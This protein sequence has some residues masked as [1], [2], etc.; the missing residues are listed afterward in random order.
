MTRSAV[1]SLSYVPFPRSLNPNGYSDA[2]AGNDLE[3]GAYT[4]LE[5]SSAESITQ[6]SAAFRHEGLELALERLGHA[7]AP[8][9]GDGQGRGIGEDVLVAFLQ[10]IEDALRRRL[11]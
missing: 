9:L 1:I 7:H 8:A 6:H 2:A 5:G 10:A 11:G 4:T 3:L